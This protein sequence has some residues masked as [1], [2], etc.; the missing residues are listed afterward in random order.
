[1]NGFDL[2]FDPLNPVEPGPLSIYS[3]QNAY[4]LGQGFGLALR[5]LK[6][7]YTTLRTL[8]VKIFNPLDRFMPAF[9]G[10][11]RVHESKNQGRGKNFLEPNTSRTGQHRVSQ[12]D[13]QRQAI[14]W[15]IYKP[16]PYVK[17]KWIEIKRYDP[18]D[19][20]PHGNVPGPHIHSRTASGKKLPVRPARVSEM[21]ARDRRRLEK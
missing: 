16:N 4:A 13:E 2:S 18:I 12:R 20:A 7:G 1:M 15:A 6:D 3:A 19:S 10:I 17:G 11:M 8:G 9:S 21:T 5:A 14:R